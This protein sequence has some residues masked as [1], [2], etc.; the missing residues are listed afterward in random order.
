[1]CQALA[2]VVSGCLGSF[3]VFLDKTRSIISKL[4]FNLHLECTI[5]KKNRWASCKCWYTVVGELAI[6]LHS[7]HQGGEGILQM[8]RHW[9]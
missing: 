3:V 6:V 8:S 2:Q 4:L 9:F 7:I 5:A 1:M